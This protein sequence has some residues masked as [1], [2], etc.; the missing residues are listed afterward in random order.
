MLASLHQSVALDRDSAEHAA[1]NTEATRAAKEATATR[2]AVE[3]LEKRL[4]VIG[5]GQW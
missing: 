4:D 1:I 5:D 3:R 2:K